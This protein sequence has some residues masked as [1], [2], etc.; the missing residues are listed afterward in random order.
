MSRP[1]RMHRRA[2]RARTDALHE[3]S[4]HLRHRHSRGL[5]CNVDTHGPTHSIKRHRTCCHSH[6]CVPT[7]P[8]R[9]T[10]R[11]TTALAATA[12]Y[13]HG[14]P[15]PTRRMKRHRACCHKR[16]RAPARTARA[17]ALHKAP[18]HLLPPP[19]PRTGAQTRHKL[20]AHYAPTGLRRPARIGLALRAP[21]AVLRLTFTVPRCR[22]ATSGAFGDCRRGLHWQRISRYR[23]SLPPHSC[24]RQSCLSIAA[25]AENPHNPTHAPR[26]CDNLTVKRL[27]HA[28]NKITI[29]LGGMAVYGRGKEEAPPCPRRRAAVRRVRLLRQGLPARSD[30]HCGRGVRARGRGKV[31]GLWQVR[32]RMSGVGYRHV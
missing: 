31:R 28:Y 29:S 18:P 20:N 30:R 21:Q 9:R 23:T 15:E 2:S 1:G 3:A 10:A 14:M 13:A 16:S 32:S 4:P 26:K 25:V 12:A 7:R 6:S 24:P 22:P 11:S 5:A 19:Q 27:A 17:D 8:N